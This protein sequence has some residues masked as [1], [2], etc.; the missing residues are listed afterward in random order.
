MPEVLNE[1]A[2]TDSEGARRRRLVGPLFLAIVIQVLLVAMTLFVV[3]LVPSARE[4]PKFVAKKTIYLPQRELQH[5]MAVAE[6]QQ[7]AP[8]PMQMEK[9]QVERLTPD[10][11]PQLPALPTMEFTPIVPDNPSPIG[12]AMF[13]NSGLGGMMD[14]LVGEASS[15]S[16]LG[17]NDSVKRVV[18]IVDVAT[19]VFNAAESAG[20]SMEEVKNETISLINKL[21]SNTLFNVILHRRT[22]LVLRDTMVTATVSNKESAVQWLIEKFPSDASA[23]LSG[24]VSGPNGTSGI[25]PILGRAFDMNPDSIFLISDGGYF[26]QANRAV[27]LREVLDLIGD[28]QDQMEEE[29]RIHTVR[30][31]DPRNIDDDRVGSGMRSIAGRNNGKYRTFD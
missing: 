13:G 30:F 14:G 31:P 26:D 29:V 9:I 10:N 3:V 7:S 24:A 5:K 19:S 28:R 22:F 15:I 1:N 4:D 6:F 17:I 20:F 25:I 16:F 18:I 11:L 27:P 8:S 2:I 23:S 21:N 12:N